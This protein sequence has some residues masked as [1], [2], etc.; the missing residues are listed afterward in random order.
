MLANMALKK[1]AVT[2]LGRQISSLQSRAASQ[3]YPY[4]PKLLSIWLRHLTG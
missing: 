4:S 2:F 3:S 1:L